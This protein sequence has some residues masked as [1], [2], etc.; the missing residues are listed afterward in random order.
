MLSC[1]SIQYK[2]SL[3]TLVILLALT[4]NAQATSS[5]ITAPQAL[6]ITLEPA[7]LKVELKKTPIEQRSLFY[8]EYL[9]KY[10]PRALVIRGRFLAN[11]TP[12]QIN[13]TLED[14]VSLLKTDT[15]FYF[16]NKPDRVKIGFYW[17]AIV[18]QISLISEFLQ[19]AHVD[20]QT[21]TVF[22][23]KPL[24]FGIGSSLMNCSFLR[25]TPL[26]P[27]K[28]LLVYMKENR[29]ESTG[30]FYA[31]YFDFVVKL[32]NEGILFKDLLPAQRYFH[33]LEFVMTKLRGT[34]FDRQ[35]QEPLNVCKELL[36][37]LQANIAAIEEEDDFEDLDDDADELS[38][39]KRKP[40]TRAT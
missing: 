6:D 7:I 5:E 40:K 8:E 20:L 39:K 22:L 23:I 30:K 12:Q 17:E 4:V 14:I 35:Y 10:F 27:M 13:Q 9:A 11:M 29:L 18:D 21:Q 33:E 24:M 16:T 37:I 1:L 34:P 32:F 31:T 36:A 28:Q 3:F 2:N 15:A 25:K 19:K 38:P 26:P